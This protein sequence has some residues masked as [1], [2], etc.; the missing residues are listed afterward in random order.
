MEKIKKTLGKV[1]KNKKLRRY[2]H[3]SFVTFVTFFIP[4][5]YLE[6]KRIGVEGFINAGLLGLGAVSWRL[7]LKAIYETLMS[8]LSKKV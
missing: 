2:L 3:S 5:A 7:I 1:W 8:S 4:I 6:L